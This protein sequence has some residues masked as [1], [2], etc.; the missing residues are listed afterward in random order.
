MKVDVFT[1]HVFNNGQQLLVLRNCWILWELENETLKCSDLCSCVSHRLNSHSSV[2]VAHR[3]DC[4][5]DQRNIVI[6]WQKVKASLLH[7]NMALYTIKYDLL[8]L[9]HTFHDVYNGL[10]KHGKLHFF[11]SMSAFRIL[12]V[13]LSHFFAR[14]AEVFWHLLSRNNWYLKELSGQSEAT[15]V[16]DHR[17]TAENVFTEFLLNVAF[18]KETIFWCYPEELLAMLH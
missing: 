8:P 16:V 2:M 5:Y 14:D 15:S 12:I 13:S 1:W 11:E 18:E 6:S 4:I 10:F 17:G 3:A 9:R 7:T